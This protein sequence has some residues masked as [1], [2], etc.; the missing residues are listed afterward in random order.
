MSDGSVSTYETAW[1]SSIITKEMIQGYADEGF[2]VL[3]IP[4]A[5]S[6]KMVQDGSY[7]IDS[8]WMARITQ[9]V[10]WTLEADMYAIVNIHWDNAW[11]NTFPENKGEYMKCYETMWYQISDN[12]KD[13][14]DY[15]MFES[16]N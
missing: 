9:I 7:T 12:F 5:W 13:Y 10:D 11:V 16:Q 8:D 2:F 1:G 3:R 6:N 14:T 15:L 4:V